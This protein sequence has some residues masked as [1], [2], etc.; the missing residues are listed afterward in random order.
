[1]ALEPP[2]PLKATPL[3]KKGTKLVDK[4]TQSSPRR[5]STAHHSRDV[6]QAASPRLIEDAVRIFLALGITATDLHLRARPGSALAE[7]ADAM[8]LQAGTP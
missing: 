2:G 8:D 1:M 3:R 5:R 6:T 7:L 4:V